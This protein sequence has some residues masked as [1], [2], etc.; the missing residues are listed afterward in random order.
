MVGGRRSRAA[1]LGA[2]LS[3]LSA[4]GKTEDPAASSGI[5]A[6]GPAERAVPAAALP[7]LGTVG[8]LPPADRRLVVAMTEDG[9]FVSEAGEVDAAGLEALLRRKARE[10][11]GDVH[12]STALRLV[13]R[14]PATAPWGSTVRLMKAAAD[15]SVKAWRLFFA[16]RPED[17]G[18]EGA[19]GAWLPLDLDGAPPPPG[20]TTRVRVR[21]GDSAPDEG[22]V[23]GDLEEAV[24][25]AGKGPVELS[26]SAGTRTGLVL[27]LADLAWQAGASGVVFEGIR[28]GATATP[29][30]GARVRV[31]GRDVVPMGDPPPPRRARVRGRLAGVPADGQPPTV[32]HEPELKDDAAEEE[33]AASPPGE[34]RALAEH[35]SATYAVRLGA[36]WLVAHRSPKGG[37][38]VREWARFCH[39]EP[40]ESHVEGETGDARNDGLVTALAVLAL[41]ASGRTHLSADP[42]GRAV[43]EA[44]LFLVGRQGAD[45]RVDSA[46]PPLAHAAATLAWVE[47]YR[48]TRTN[49]LADATQ[50]ALDLCARWARDPARAGPDAAGDGALAAWTTLALLEA[51]RAGE[52][53]DA[54][55]RP[56]AFSVADDVVPRARARLEAAGLPGRA[57]SGQI[58]S[59]FLT[60]LLRPR[61]SPAV[62]RAERTAFADV[63]LRL[64]RTDGEACG[65]RGSWEA[66][67]ADAYRAGRVAATA[68][69][70][71]TLLAHDLLPAPPRHTAP[72]K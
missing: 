37:W 8:D 42:D 54:A 41:V 36:D 31:E 51:R 48:A 7:V 67:D 62:L 40:F 69:S 21:A 49:T 24:R 47:V 33:P 71:L 46:G 59:A 4:C 55:G 58:T 27:R 13:F 66:A 25:R 45:G 61:E 50:R 57:R 20:R 63:L 23:L 16:A 17:D 5:P 22:A 10:A 28:A 44:L 53:D 52:E 19:M 56:R 2:A 68:L 1:A 15:P 18:P 26:C 14:V 43:R 3:L 9:R 30:P 32:W 34:R 38:S 64:Q 39:G 11:G 29:S 70:M 72:G 6:S 12:G 65:F 60:V 35:G